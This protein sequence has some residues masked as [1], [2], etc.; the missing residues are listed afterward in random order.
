MARSVSPSVRLVAVA[1]WIMAAF[2][3]VP[4][5]LLLRDVRARPF[6]YSPWLVPEPFSHNLEKGI[7]LCI[8]SAVVGFG[9]WKRWRWARWADMLLV[10]PKL[11][12]AYLLLIFYKLSDESPVVLV[13]VIALALDALVVTVL[14]SASARRSFVS[15][16]PANPR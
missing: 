4:F 15:Q 3:G 9:V 16:L 11:Y 5:A 7:L 13:M 6:S 8:V 14:W 2:V 10:A 12:C 1:D